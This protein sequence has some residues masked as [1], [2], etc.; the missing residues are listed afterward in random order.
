VEVDS[1][2][3][4]VLSGSEEVVQQHHPRAPDQRNRHLKELDSVS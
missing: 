1:H 2:T 3:E 4:E